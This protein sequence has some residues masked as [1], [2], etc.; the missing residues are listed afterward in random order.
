MGDNWHFSCWKLGQFLGGESSR[1]YFM[2]TCSVLEGLSFLSLKLTL[3][4]LSFDW[5]LLF[6]V[7]GFGLYVIVEAGPFLTQQPFLGMNSFSPS[8]AALTTGFII[9]QDIGWESPEASDSGLEVVVV[10]VAAATAAYPEWG[11]CGSNQ[12]VLP[13]HLHHG[14]LHE[15]V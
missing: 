13:A 6:W 1:K 4:W 7:V 15:G 2:Q 5:Q 11:P 12:Q 8:L 3:L 10:V 9:S 14:G